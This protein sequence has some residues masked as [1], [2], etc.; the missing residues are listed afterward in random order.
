MTAFLVDQQLPAALA[1]HLTDLRQ[2]SKHIK[3]YPGGATLK[4]SAIAALAD[5]EGRMVV[6]KDDDFR[7]MHLTRKVPRRMVLV[8]VGN[9][10]TADLLALVDRY[11][12]ELISAAVQY[13][14]VELS[15]QGVFVY[16]PQ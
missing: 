5:A 11:F 3:W 6:T 13:E 1:S 12:A 7:L 4:D 14:L 16:D 9:I 2:D 8:T 10:A 15:R